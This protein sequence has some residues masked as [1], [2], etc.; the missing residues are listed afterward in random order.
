MLKLKVALALVKKMFK[1]KVQAE[2]TGKGC[3]CGE[4]P[5]VVQEAVAEVIAAVKKK[6]AP[7]KAAPKKAS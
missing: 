5:A 1:K 3:G 7:K 2:D 4:I 6:A